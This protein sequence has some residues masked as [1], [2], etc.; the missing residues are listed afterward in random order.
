M[1]YYNTTKETGELLKQSEKKAM[2]QEKKLRGLFAILVKMSPSQALKY[3]PKNT[4]ITSVRR[5]ITN[6]KNEGYLIKTN[7]KVPGLYGK[8]E[9]IYK[10]KTGQLEMF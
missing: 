3:F 8:P 6:L 2:T 9:Y 1:S 10:R 5:G 4:P 7:I